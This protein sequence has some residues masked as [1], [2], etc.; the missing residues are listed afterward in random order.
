MSQVSHSRSGNNTGARSKKSSR[1]RGR[2]WRFTLNNYTI[3][4]IKKM[5][6]GEMFTPR[7]VLKYIV[8]EEIGKS[9][10]PHLQGAV[11][12]AQLTDFNVIKKLLPRANLDTIGRDHEAQFHYCGKVKSRSG[13]IWTYGEAEKY[14]EKERKSHEDFLT[15]LYTS[16]TGLKKGIKE[17]SINWNQKMKEEMIYKAYLK[18]IEE[19]VVAMHPNLTSLT[20]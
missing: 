8:Q 18:E 11:Q 12:F 16:A 17:L 1:S 5:E 19:E 4:D 2:S 10:T 6:S 14:I 15:E 9:G 20:N 13:K 7:K 3:E